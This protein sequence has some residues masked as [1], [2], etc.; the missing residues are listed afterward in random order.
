[1]VGSVGVNAAGF[2]EHRVA[3][4]SVAGSTSWAPATSRVNSY[5]DALAELQAG[6]VVTDCAQSAGPPVPEHGGRQ[7]VPV[8]VTIG[9]A[10][11]RVGDLDDDA[12]WFGLG[13][14]FGGLV[15]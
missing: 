11:A 1:M 2:S 7:H 15:A 14:P 5:D 13:E 8:G 12:A 3:L 10:H 9:A 4:S 6:P